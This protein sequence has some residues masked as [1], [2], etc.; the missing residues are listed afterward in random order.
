MALVSPTTTSGAQHM[1]T[2]RSLLALEYSATQTRA[3][4]LGVVKGQLRLIAQGAAL[5]EEANS[6]RA[7]LAPITHA[8]GRQSWDSAGLLTPE[9][10]AG[11][12][13][14]RVIVISD[15]AGSHYLSA[16]RLT[17]LTALTR[18]AT[19]LAEFGD[20]NALMIEIGA[21]ATR[22]AYATNDGEVAQWSAPGISGGSE[23]MTHIGAQL[24]T[25]L[26][27][28]KP[29]PAVDV[30]LGTGI[31]LGH[32]LPIAEVTYALL[33]G[34][35]PHGV[36]QVFFDVANCALAFG[37]A[38]LLN[39][40]LA[41]DGL[42]R[43]ALAIY[44]ATCVIPQ[45]QVSAGD[46]YSLRAEM[47]YGAGQVEVIEIPAGAVTIIPLA[48]GQHAKLHLFP[49]PGVDCGGGQGEPVSTISAIAGGRLGVIIDTRSLRSSQMTP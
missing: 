15:R 1:L 31:H 18:C 23:D 17:P 33:A 39:P 9:S 34:L 48:L 7:A 3:T 46:T 42:L 28:V 2:P 4:L 44:A 49:A 6:V 14:D 45:G 12:G 5:A 41:R 24:R 27:D 11:D 38:S 22:I 13:C 10:A 47:V 40:A 21:D 25:A 35:C 36:C 37:A 30:I 19:M 32:G 26:Q 29:M 43:D 8:T 16:P 20:R